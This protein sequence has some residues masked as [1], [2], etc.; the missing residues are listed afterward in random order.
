MRSA[1]CRGSLRR[2]SRYVMRRRIRSQLR[3]ARTMI[4]GLNTLS[5]LFVSGPTVRISAI[6]AS[7]QTPIPVTRRFRDRLSR[8]FLVLVGGPAGVERTND[9]GCTPAL[10]WV[11]VP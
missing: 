5:E 1:G 4:P 10:G 8:L 6:V 2:L 11:A 7:H 3:M 9:W